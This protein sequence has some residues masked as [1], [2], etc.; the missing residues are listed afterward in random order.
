MTAEQNP[1]LAALQARL[2]SLEDRLRL[3]RVEVDHLQNEL[4]K[5]RAELAAYAA[6][7][8]PAAT[9]TQP[10]SRPITKSMGSFA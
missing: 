2:Q 4:A 9:P 7:P 1:Q 3:T 5:V 8:S 10:T 6:G